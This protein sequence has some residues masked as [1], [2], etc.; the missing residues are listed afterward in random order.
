[1]TSPLKP[2]ETPFKAEGPQPLVWQV[3]PGAPY[4]VD[5]LGPFKPAVVS[6]KGKTQAPIALPAQSALAVAS[7][8]VQGFADVETLGGR[9]P[10]SLYLLT[11][12][13]SGERKSACDAPL[14]EELRQHELEEN[15]KYSKARQAW[16][17][18]HTA[19][20]A[21]RDRIVLDAKKNKESDTADVEAELEVLGPEPEPPLSPDRTV[22]EPTFEGLT[23][24][25]AVGQPSLGL[26][27]DEGG[28][29]LGGHA[30]NR[31]NRQKTLAALNDLWQ[32][33]PI[34]RTRAGDGHF[35]LYGRRFAV[36]LMVQPTVARTFMADPL[37][38]DTGFLPRFLICEPPSTIGT[39][40]HENAVEDFMKVHAFRSRL[41]LILGR[42]L[43]TVPHGREL[44]PRLV[45]LS[46]CARKL[47]VEF[48]DETEIAQAP[49]G[50]FSHVTGTASKAAEQAARIAGV[51]TLWKDLDAQ[52]VDAVDMANA[53]ELARY[54]L[55]EAS[56]LASVAQI[57]SEVAQ[58]EKLRDWLL[59]GFDEDV[60]LVRDI[61]RIGPYSLRESLKARAAIEMLEAHGWLNKLEKHAEVR[62]SRRKEAWRIVRPTE[63]AN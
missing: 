32:A 29:F 33:N 7:L 45:K 59:K 2:V 44:T 56:R 4:P 18:K 60:V 43:P 49:S 11:I 38:A 21:K 13:Q 20:K 16:Q 46:E 9:R 51:M 41:Q 23:K 42:E 57:S 10:T 40:L 24:L 3:P 58:A 35:A 63:N 17:I 25:L 37:A 48:A 8:G 14:M 12:A 28:Q 54:Y 55:G 53:I 62:G 36:H 19:W 39:R 61:L 22:T 6:V 27:S 30:M 15:K 5:A 50:E 31:D 1:M 52:E 26:F 47:L 34:R